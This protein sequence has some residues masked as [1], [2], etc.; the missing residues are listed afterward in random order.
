M[1]Q[2]ASENRRFTSQAGPRPDHRCELS[3][4]SYAV[5]TA[6]QH[7]NRESRAQVCCA[8]MLVTAG[9]RNLLPSGKLDRA[10]MVQ[11]IIERVIVNW[12]CVSLDSFGGTVAGAGDC[13]SGS[14]HRQFSQWQ[15]GGCTSDACEASILQHD[16]TEATQQVPEQLPQFRTAA[17]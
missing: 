1:S 14:E 10:E 17:V 16:C 2:K 4:R 12:T 6:N 15:I 8:D 11:S 7:V 13:A 9:K 3:A 5:E